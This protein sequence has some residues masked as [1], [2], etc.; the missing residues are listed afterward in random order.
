MDYK[1]QHVRVRDHLSLCVC[2]S[3][4]QS[5]LHLRKSLIN[6]IIIWGNETGQ[7]DNNIIQDELLRY[8]TEN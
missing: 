1:V 6:L 5:E 8:A 4:V 2:P 7:E 3:T